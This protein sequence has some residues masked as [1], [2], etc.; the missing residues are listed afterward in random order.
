M[1]GYSVIEVSDPAE[2]GRMALVDP[3]AAV[4]A[5]LWMPGISGVQLC[6][7][8]K[9]EPGTENVPVILRGPDA[10]RN[11]FWAER[12]GAAAYVVKGRMGD[13]GRALTSAIANA[14][15]NDGFITQLSGDTADLR[16]R[17]AVHLDAAL[18]DSVIASEVRALGTCGAFDRLF[19][20]FSQ[21]VSQIA[22]YRWLAVSTDQPRRFALHANPNARALAERE[23][24]A[25]LHLDEDVTLVLV[26]DEDASEDAEGA[27][28][29]VMPIQLGGTRI[30]EIALAGRSGDDAHVAQLVTVLAREVAGPIRMASL[31]EESQLLATIDPLTGL[32]NRRALLEALG[33]EIARAARY[34]HALSILLLDLDHFKSIN[35]KHGHA[36]GDAVLSSTGAL[37]SK[38]A[39]KGDMVARWG[40]EE[41]LVVLHATPAEGAQIA[42]ERVRRAICELRVSSPAGERIAVSASIG[43]SS[44]QAGDGIDPL[45]DRAD[46][47]MYQAKSGGRNRVVLSLGAASPPAVAAASAE[48]DAVMKRAEPTLSALEH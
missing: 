17:I 40:G 27:E 7:L 16:D 14:A 13:L 38:Q 22:S 10:Q 8:L 36:S 39:R 35:D 2:G 3:P 33:A 30:G 11:R 32:M 42:A 4:V 9:A 37:L 48:A 25:A 5:D 1:Q 20:L 31:V 24:R 47:A 18:F 41:F 19:D 45:I 23:A 26:E 44:F 34:G 46:R 12:A 6:R 15:P 29:I 21:L 43:V 28:V